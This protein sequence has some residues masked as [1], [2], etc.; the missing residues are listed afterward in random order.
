MLSQEGWVVMFSLD[1][2]Y[3]C[4]GSL[5]S[6]PQGEP[7]VPTWRALLSGLLQSHMVSFRVPPT[8]ALYSLLCGIL[9]NHV[10][11]FVLYPADT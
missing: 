11:C 5:V 6:S 8:G 9:L 10:W 2:N 4:K 7:A 1:W 3:L